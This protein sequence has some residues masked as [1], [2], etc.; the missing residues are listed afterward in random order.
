MRNPRPENFDPRI[1]RRKPDAVDMTGIVPLAPKPQ[2][3]SSP[4][5]PSAAPTQP[6]EQD[7]TVSRY[8]DGMVSPPSVTVFE[9]QDDLMGQVRKAVK[10]FG[11][12][13]ATHR[14]T[15]AEKQAIAAVVFA[16]RGKNI[17]TSENEITRIA[18]NYLISEYHQ[19]GENSILH[20][21]LISLNE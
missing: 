18:I 7:T 2:V 13:A 5:P 14:F 15:Q 19:K 9:K 6:I 8:H 11:K 17:R 21:A 1:I 20:K 16:Y 12:E 3:I 4:A 10:A